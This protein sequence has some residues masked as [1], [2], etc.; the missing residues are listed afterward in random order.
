MHTQLD[1]V[2]RQMQ[3]EMAS[4]PDIVRPSKY[5]EELNKQHLIDTAS[6][7]IGSF[8]RTLARN[9]FMWTRLLPWDSQVR[10]LVSHL[11]LIATVRA[12][13]GIFAPFTHRRI[14]LFEGFALNFLTRLIWQ[15]VER[16]APKEIASL[17]E[18]TVGNPPDIKL[19]GRMISQ[20]LA[21]SVLEYK[22]FEEV[23]IESSIICE[24]GGGYG[25]NAFVTSS[26]VPGAK[27]IMADIPPALGVAQTYLGEIFPTKRHFRFRPFSNFETV[28]DEFEAADFV[29]LLPHQLMRLPN[30]CVDLFINISSLHEMRLDQIDFYL[31]EIHRLVRPDGHFYLKAWKT[32][33]IPFE[34]IVVRESDYQLDR[35][36]TVY[37]RTPKVQSRFFETLQRKPSGTSR[38]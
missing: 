27:Y 29:F 10:F 38:A 9:Y 17:T 30:S 28:R 2:L 33:K 15:Y 24:L 3:E 19:H 11:P 20:D 37:R 8:K 7:G 25:R 6:E 14:P 13:L 21:N 18:P 4:A 1:A 12:A 22:S 35:W 36:Q 5:W 34:E 31:E 16:E 32:S 26:L 23:A